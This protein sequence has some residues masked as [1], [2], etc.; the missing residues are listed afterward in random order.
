MQEIDI[1]AKFFATEIMKFAINNLKKIKPIIDKENYI[2]YFNNQNKIIELH[3][4]DDKEF[5][6]M[7]GT[8][9]TKFTSDFIKNIVNDEV[10]N[11][12][13]NIYKAVEKDGNLDNL[14]ISEVFFYN[15]NEEEQCRK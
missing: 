11:F 14:Y 6:F 7:T 4:N 5:I 1:F 15:M 13:N 3:Y 2:V 8:T 12:L 10:Y 9:N